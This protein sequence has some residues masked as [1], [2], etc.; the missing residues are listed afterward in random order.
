MKVTRLYPGADG[1]SH[2]E[3]IEVETNKL[4]PGDGIVFR[5]TIPPTMLTVGIAH[6]DGSR[7]A[8][9][10]SPSNEKKRITLEQN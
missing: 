9:Y 8:L 5:D 10:S 6:R 3:E 1:Q 2:F 7:A 4:Q